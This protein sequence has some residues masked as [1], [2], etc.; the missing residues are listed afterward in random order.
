MPTDSQS[1]LEHDVTDQRA[2]VDATLDEIQHRLT[3][4]QLIDEVLR[5][6]RAPGADFAASL[7]RTLAANPIPTAL[8]GVGLMWLLLAPKPVSNASVPAAS[9]PDELGD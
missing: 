5:H 6:G 9:T 2:R 8:V 7:G 1:D 3:P 4:G